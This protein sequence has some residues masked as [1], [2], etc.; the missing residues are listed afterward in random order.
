MRLIPTRPGLT[1][2]KC[3]E[4]ATIL[5]L[6]IA[7]CIKILKEYIPYYAV[8]HTWMKVMYYVAELEYVTYYER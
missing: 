4:L 5:L 6:D 8:L 3:W 2:H 1:S 7:S